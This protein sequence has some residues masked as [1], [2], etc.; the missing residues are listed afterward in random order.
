MDASGA[1]TPSVRAS[2]ETRTDSRLRNRQREQHRRRLLNRRIKAILAGGL[3]F[4]IG[5]AATL[6]AWTDSEQA[7]GSFEAG[8]FTIDLSTNGSSWTNSSEMSFNADGMYPGS[9][10]Y[11][12]VFV[13]TTPNTTMDGQLS[14][15]SAGATG[16]SSGIAGSLEYRA[17]TTSL[18][19]GGTPDFKC[20]EGS[21]AGSL[22]NIFGSTSNPRLKLNAP[23]T[24]VGKQDVTNNAGSVRAYC[25][26]VTLPTNTPSS[27]QGSTAANVWK[28][29]AESVPT[30]KTS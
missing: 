16:S 23:A 22:T 29:D 17:V 12:P 20:N 8:K 9:K 27:A 26:E 25:F 4:G 10:V 2:N 5:A 18:A 13:R 15:S 30:K 28:F 14:V 21:F 1:P 7:T 24:G 19:S 6:A 3:V 11:A